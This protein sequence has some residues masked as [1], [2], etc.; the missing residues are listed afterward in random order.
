MQAAVIIG[1]IHREELSLPFQQTAAVLHDAGI[2]C[3]INPASPVSADFIFFFQSY[4]YEFSKK[5]LQRWRETAPLASRFFIL[6]T[7]CEGMMRT[8]PII[9]SPVYTYVHSWNKHGWKPEYLR[10]ISRTPPVSVPSSANTEKQDVCILSSFGPF[11]NDPAMNLFLAER[12]GKDQ[13]HI[14]P[15]SKIPP[16]FSGVIIADTDDSPPANILSAL[17]R[18]RTQFIRHEITLYV[19][20]PR[21]HEKKD[22]YLAGASAVLDKHFWG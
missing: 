9:D 18:L 12:Y 2:A 4:P 15:V 1:R 10:A 14:F 16:F 22:L 8:A 13:R 17:Q 3:N 5:T 7:C 19:H 20:S 6:G 21:L 11:G